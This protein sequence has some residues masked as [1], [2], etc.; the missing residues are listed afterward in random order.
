[1]TESLEQLQRTLDEYS[2][3]LDSS[4]KYN[5]FFQIKKKGEMSRRLLVTNTGYEITLSERAQSY[6]LKDF[7]DKHELLNWLTTDAVKA[8]VFECK[9]KSKICPSVDFDKIYLEQKE[10]MQMINDEWARRYY[11]ECM[12]YM[13]NVLKFTD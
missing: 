6:L 13:K 7:S 1:M 9:Y 12:E 5:S 3:L 2:L 11:A 8:M 10:L 4:G